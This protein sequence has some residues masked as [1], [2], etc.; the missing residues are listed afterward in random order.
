MHA[1]P[2]ATIAIATLLFG[3][4][5]N[6]D[7]DKI[8]DRAAIRT[9]KRKWQEKEIHDYVFV[10]KETCNC[11][12]PDGM[13]IRVEVK[14]DKPVG[15][16][17]AH[18]G[19]PAPGQTVTID[20]LFDNVLT[21]SEVG[22]DQFDVDFDKERNFIKQVAIDPDE[23]TEDDEYGFNIPCFSTED[24]FCEFPLITAEECQQSNGT[25]KPIP[26]DD[27]EKVCGDDPVHSTFGQVE[28]DVSV[29]C[30]E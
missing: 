16:I 26:E 22:V 3:C 30:A 23:K 4:D 20:D 27:P 13:G 24:T 9:A 25:V 7:V 6:F 29:C 11:F 28:R 10:F 21:R 15:A 5:V 14:D 2:F 1:R 12:T 18:N 8:V 17:G 19:I